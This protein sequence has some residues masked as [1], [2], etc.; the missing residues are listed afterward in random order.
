[1]YC[2]AHCYLLFGDFHLLIPL[3]LAESVLT[4]EDIFVLHHFLRSILEFARS[5]K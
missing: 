4:A 3:E 5:L 2:M 1:M